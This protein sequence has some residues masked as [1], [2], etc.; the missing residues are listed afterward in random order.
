MRMVLG[1]G[2]VNVEIGVYCG[3]ETASS[4]IRICIVLAA[5]YNTFL[6]YRSIINTS[7]ILAERVSKIIQINICESIVF[8][9]V[10]TIS[11]FAFHYGIIRLS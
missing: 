1:P 3:W 11:V 8:E 9:L 4:Q 10:P 6:A 7:N 5:I 2:D